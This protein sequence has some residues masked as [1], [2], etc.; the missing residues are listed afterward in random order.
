MVVP[1]D[2]PQLVL[3]LLFVVPG[4]VFH[5]VRSR[6]RGLTRGPVS[7]R[8]AGAAVLV[9]LLAVPAA[10]AAA[11]HYRLEHGWTPKISRNP[12][13]RAW[14][15]AFRGRVHGFVRL[16][17]ESGE[18]FGGWFGRRSFASSYPEPRELFVEKA[19]R[20]DDAGRFTEEELYTEGMYV[21]CDDLRVVEFLGPGLREEV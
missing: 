12:S 16:R 6:L 3:L 7:P 4:S 13:P 17:T 5:A 10:L 9:L 20:L 11:D 8:A 15:T 1:G 19:W 2:V 14:D 21:R 18:W